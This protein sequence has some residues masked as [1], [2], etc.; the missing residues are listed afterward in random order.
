MV[1]GEEGSIVVFIVKYF[2]VQVESMEGV[3]FSYVVL[4]YGIFVL[5]LRFISNYVEWCQ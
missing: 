5:Q 1:Y 2:F 4:Q 3:V